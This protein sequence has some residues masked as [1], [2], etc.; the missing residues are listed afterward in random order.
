MENK[1]KAK[2]LYKRHIKITIEWGGVDGLF[3]NCSDM[4]ITGVEELLGILRLSDGKKI[5][6]K[7]TNLISKEYAR[8]EN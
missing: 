5:D 7:I 4:S 8:E 3:A 1:E 6:E 2:L